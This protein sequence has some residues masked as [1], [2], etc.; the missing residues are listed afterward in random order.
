MVGI[1]LCGNKNML[2]RVSIINSK[3]ET[4]Y[5][6]FVQPT[7]KVTDYRTPVSGIRPEDIEHGETFA[8]VK[9]EVTQIIENKLLVGH[10]VEHDF[11]ALQISHPKNM[12]RDT[13]MYSKFL[14]LTKGQTPSLKRLALH[15]LGANIQEGEHSSVQDA[16]AALQLYMLVR[17]DWE[18]QFK[19]SNRFYSNENKLYDGSQNNLQNNFFVQVIYSSVYGCCPNKFR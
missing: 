6:K 2:A 12:I 16:K 18:S 15:F 10:S 7:A 8:I 13:S 11:K 14:Q 17:N 5:D 9:K 19:K 3:Y 1:N 4:I